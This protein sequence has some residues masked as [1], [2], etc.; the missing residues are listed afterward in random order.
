[1]KAIR[2]LWLLA[3]HFLLLPLAEA[4]VKPAL[5]IVESG[6]YVDRILVMVSAFEWIDN[7]RLVFRGFA[8]DEKDRAE[9]DDP[10]IKVWNT[11]QNSIT[12]YK[13]IRHACFKGGLIRY[14]EPGNEPEK[15][16]KYIWWEGPLGN[17]QRAEQP[18][19]PRTK[20]ME[21][22]IATQVKNPFHCKTLFRDELLPP[23]KDNEREIIALREGDGYLTAE[24]KGSQQR[25]E[26]LRDFR[27]KAEPMKWYHP[28]KPDGVPINIEMRI[29]SFYTPRVSGYSEFGRGYVVLGA[30]PSVLGLTGPEAVKQ[31]IPHRIFL[32]R[33]ST[34]QL[35]IVEVPRVVSS[36]GQPEP[37]KA[38]WVFAGSDSARRHEYGLYRFDAQKVTM[39]ERGVVT[40][41]SVSPNGCKVAYAINTEYLEMASPIRVKLINFCN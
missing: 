5:K 39:I 12:P 32:F 23:V 28:S 14:G 33:P 21:Y 30:Q 22:R 19:V 1:M 34:Q 7:D 8:R 31:Q 3:T 2:I 20:E 26:Q 16:G 4:Q 40:R 11:V 36:V 15:S 18:Y 13:N 27:G 24:L 25:Q 10:K 17:E 35:D 6:Y 9:V 38:G 41:L 29:G 37:S